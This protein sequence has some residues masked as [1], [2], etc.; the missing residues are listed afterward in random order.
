[1]KLRFPDIYGSLK[2]AMRT[3]SR[4][5][6]YENVNITTMIKNKYFG[7]VSGEIKKQFKQQWSLIL[8]PLKA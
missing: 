3:S 8:V 4:E 7:L 2:S 1:M 5:L 6:N